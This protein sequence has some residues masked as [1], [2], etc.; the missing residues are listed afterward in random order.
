VK[1]LLMAAGVCL[2]AAVWSPAPAI[3]QTPQATGTLAGTVVAETG[4]TLPGAVVTVIGASG[5]AGRPAALRREAIT[6]ADGA[7]VVAD[8]PP[9]R[10]TLT[11]LA[12]GF[13]VNAAVEATVVA[14]QTR[15][16]VINMR[17]TGVTETVV[18]HASPAAASTAPSLLTVTPKEVATVA[19]AAE[20]VF[21]V[22]HTLPGITSVNDFD[23][24]LSV[25]GGGPD[26][27]L[28][29]MD[30]VEIHNPYRLFGLTSAFNPET[31]EAFELTAGAF[32][33]RFGDRLSSILTIDNRAGNPARRV[34]G[35]ATLAL[36]DANMIAEGRLP[37]T[38]QGSWL[39]SG[40]R[41]YYDLVAERFIDADLPS[42]TDVQA[43]A[44]WRLRNGGQLAVFG[45]KSRENTDAEFSNEGPEYA[46]IR[47]QARNDVVAVSLQQSF[48]TRVSSR[49]VASWYLNRDDIDFDGRFETGARRSNARDDQDSE[50]LSDVLF[51][52][53]LSVRDVA[54]RQDTTLRV[55]RGHLLDV[56]AEAHVLATRWGWRIDG[57]RNPAAANGS[58]V[59]GGAG[60]PSL[61]DSARD[62][63]RLGAWVSG[64]WMLKP[65]LRVDPGL[66]L[67]T[68]SV[69]GRAS[70]S[71]R[72][73]LLADLTTRTR[74]R[75]GGGTF[76]QSPGYEKLLQSDYFVN[77]TSENDARVGFERA[78]HAVVG[79]EHSL[80]PGVV[81]RVE[82]YS[83]TF[84]DLVIGRLETPAEIDAR[85]AVYDYP[86][87]LQS[88]IPRGALIL[89]A[90]TNGGRGRATGV[91]FYLARQSVPSANRKLTG[92][93]S[94]TRS[95]AEKTVYGITMPAD[96]D[97]PH[98][99][100]LVANLRVNATIEIATTVRVQS[101][102]PYSP[103]VGVRV[104]PVKDVLDVDAD[105]NR[106]EL[107]PQ[108][109]RGGLVWTF[110]SGG[111]SNLNSA[112]LP[113]FSRVDARITFR[114]GWM[115]RRWHFYV[116]VINLLNA[117]NAS[118]FD[119][120][121]SYDP[122]ADRPQI[123]YVRQNSLPL[124]PSLGI[125]YRF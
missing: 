124:L 64:V 44:V 28:T 107:I 15:R 70:L 106:E 52:R 110:D 78:T 75:L 26:Q 9:A 67:D 69:T 30:G 80:A 42:F 49:T 60:L 102:F 101:G 47:T 120:Q 83:K 55:G 53:R 45:L 56:G 125:R 54:I 59:Q 96:Y 95:R 24:R 4:L 113:V 111:V 48:G 104:A 123:T 81:A 25:R 68:T 61:L 90:P 36:T 99:F 92:W 97:R 38:S 66:R 50:P 46:A 77:L 115:A 19:G 58:S 116:D 119:A 13:T 73:S 41:T 8:L 91:E 43:R 35:S 89:S 63:W 121:L 18:V 27:N 84:R 2:V 6:D 114:P 65:W 122:N 33:A 87:S 14:G 72:A 74:L 108:V 34:M 22:L 21:K 57:E 105:G 31:V 23:S 76:T 117:D 79:L 10:Y 16:V 3:A 17:V 100:S 12:A 5:A 32:P 112:R 71:P 11:A 1:T 82:G 88:E 7:F 98:A 40:R 94:Y 118:G 20:N 37:G 86:A 51:T 62:S 93:M 103:P 39:I 85:T 29:V 109:S